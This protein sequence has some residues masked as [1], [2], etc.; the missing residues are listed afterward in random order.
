MSRNYAPALP[1]G[2]KK[3]NNQDKK[4]QDQLQES[5]IGPTLPPEWSRSVSPVE[6]YGPQPL[7]GVSKAE[8]KAFELQQ[9]IQEIEDRASKGPKPKV[10]EK[11][12]KRES[13]MMVPPPAMRSGAPN[14][15]K[16]RSFS[17]NGTV[18]NVDQSGWTQQPG[19]ET[20]AKRFKPNPKVSSQRDVEYKEI[21]D[22]YNKVHRPSSL[23]EQHQEKYTKDTLAD[24]NLESTKFNRE[25]D[26]VGK[27]LDSKAREKLIND[28]KKLS[29]KFS[30]GD[31]SYL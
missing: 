31:S 18:D 1:P 19:A 2:F 14:D 3:S 4:S 9:K 7:Q 25:R 29:S 6:D 30:H 15:M 22:T 16:S 24:T 27:S 10:E 17:R 23:M 13:W 11:T 26:I 12:L 20:N 5:Q 8:I 28:S 21:V